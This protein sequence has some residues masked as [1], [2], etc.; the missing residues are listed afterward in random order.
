MEPFRIAIAGLGTVGAGVV[1]ELQTNA[2]LIEAR[3]RRP[4]EI[5]AIC[6]RDK[7]SDRGVG[8]SGYDWVEADCF[9]LRLR[10]LTRLSS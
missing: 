8:L 6:D 9:K 7:D 2:A 4:I 1:E 5:A 10:G 3:T